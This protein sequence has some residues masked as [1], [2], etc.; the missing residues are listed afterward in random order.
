MQVAKVHMASVLWHSEL[1]KSMGGRR[2]GWS[3]Y[4]ARTVA[5][6]SFFKE[7]IGPM[8]MGKLYG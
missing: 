1:A 5:L 2:V 6:L 4:P 3:W 7:E 8:S